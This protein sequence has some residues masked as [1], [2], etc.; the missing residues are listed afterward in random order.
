MVYSTLDYWVFGPG[1]SPGILQNAT[2]QK[3]SLFLSS[4]ER[5]GGTNSV[6]IYKKLK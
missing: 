6:E 3:L 2:L 5:M 1:P 4:G